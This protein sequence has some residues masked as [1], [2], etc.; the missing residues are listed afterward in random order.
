[1]TDLINSR[2]VLCS[3]KHNPDFSNTWTSADYSLSPELNVRM[4]LIIPAFKY[5]FVLCWPACW[6]A[7]PHPVHC[8]RWLC[9]QKCVLWKMHINVGYSVGPVGEKVSRHIKKFLDWVHND[10]HPHSASL[11]LQKYKRLWKKLGGDQYNRGFWERES[12]PWLQPCRASNAWNNKAV[13]RKRVMTSC[14]AELTGLLCV[15][16]CMITMLIRWSM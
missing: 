14:L 7:Y 6:P 4:G 10:T 8:M 15:L 13:A 2:H 5:T 3:T 12:R 9:T 16:C 1:M 11:L